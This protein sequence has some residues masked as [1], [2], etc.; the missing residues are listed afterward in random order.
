MEPR[1]GERITEPNKEVIEHSA[2]KK[3]SKRSTSPVSFRKPCD[4]CHE[5]NDVLVRCRINSTATWHLICPKK[6]WKD[7]SGG[8]IDGSLDHPYYKY[9]GVRYRSLCLLSLTKAQSTP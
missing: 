4:L 8:V 6:C 3:S 5:P 1:D 9:G 2:S 7:V